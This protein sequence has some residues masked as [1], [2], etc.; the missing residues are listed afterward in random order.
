MN[1]RLWNY[2]FT[3]KYTAIMI[4]TF[5]ISLRKQFSRLRFINL[6]RFSSTINNGENI[7][8]DPDEVD[9]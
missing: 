7:Y 9:Q 8:E 3:S 6:Q 1:K 2:F 4:S 5:S